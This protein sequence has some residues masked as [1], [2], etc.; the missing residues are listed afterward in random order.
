MPK[1]SVYYIIPEMSQSHDPK[2]IKKGISRIDGVISVSVNPKDQ[3]VAVD[4]D[5]SGTDDDEITE[6]IKA[7]GY[8]PKMISQQEHIM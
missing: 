2:E 8:S 1:E 7:L 6:Q 3:K 5:N 4:F